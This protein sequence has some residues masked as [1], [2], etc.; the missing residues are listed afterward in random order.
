MMQS[1]SMFSRLR[2]ALQVIYQVYVTCMS[3]A[4]GRKLE[5]LEENKQANHK[6]GGENES[7]KKT[8]ETV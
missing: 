7:K 8:L 4:C 3:L 5:H 2:L 6:M 1:R